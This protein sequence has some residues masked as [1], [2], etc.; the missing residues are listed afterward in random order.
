MIMKRWLEKVTK[1][2]SVMGVSISCV[3]MFSSCASM[4]S[5]REELQSVGDNEGIVFGSFIINVDKGEENES[6]WAILKGQKASDATYAAIISDSE[7]NPLKPNYVIKA[8]P[9]KEVFFIKKMQ[10]GDYQF[11]KIQK[12]G[13]TN[14]ELNLQ[15]DFRVMP[16]QTTYIGK[17]NVQ[18]P[19]RINSGSSI[20]MDVVDAQ[21][22]STIRLMND[23]GLT[24][25]EVVKSLMTI[26]CCGLAYGLDG[27][28]NDGVYFS[29]DKLFRVDVPVMLN[30]FIKKPTKISEER[31]PNGGAEVNYSVLELGEAW[32]FGALPLSSELPA[33]TKT[34]TQ[35][36]D[37]ELKR[38]IKVSGKSEV[39][40]EE[41]LQLVDGPA[42]AR[43]YYVESA[44][45][46]FVE[47]GGGAP[48]RESALIG[49]ITVLA[50]QEKLVLYA[51]GQFDMPTRGSHYTLETEKGRNKLAVQH[52]QGLRELS[53][54]LRPQ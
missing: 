17:L 12:E 41:K 53:S 32:R 51:V 37:S 10:A 13:F 28:I 2:L 22:E 1:I 8:T 52:L 21:Q 40:L 38:W 49:V 6:A 47:K 26:K 18:M 4:V 15:V 36:C 35:R 5:S 54:S 30:P 50:Q 42:L 33:E 29:P 14:V 43:I 11:L 9:E 46:L 3:I 31:R 34:L 25:T 24:S 23:Y 48:K 45:L 20:R 19:T 16:K 7:P 27:R 39:V 44:S